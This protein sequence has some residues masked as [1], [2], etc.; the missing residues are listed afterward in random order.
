METATLNLSVNQGADFI[1]SVS[2]LNPDRTP[3]DLTGYIF[4]GEGR[5][6]VQSPIIA[7]NFSYD[8]SDISNGNLIIKIPNA[9][10]TAMD[11]SENQ[12]FY[13]D[14]EMESP[15]SIVTRFFEGTIYFSPEVTR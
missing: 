11:L 14:M 10:S 15:S 6:D 3:M 12:T 2:F 9:D 13:Y 7:F 4:R 8:T 1:K 5:V